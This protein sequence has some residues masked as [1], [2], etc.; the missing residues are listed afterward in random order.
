MEQI[1]MSETSTSTQAPNGQKP[2][3]RVLEQ[4]VLLSQVLDFVGEGTE[5]AAMLV[6]KDVCKFVRLLR[7]WQEEKK[8]E[9]KQEQRIVSWRSVSRVSAF[10]SSAVSLTEWGA[11]VLDMPMTETTTQ[12][13]VKGGHIS[14]LAWLLSKDVPL[15]RSQEGACLWAAKAGQLPMLQYLRS[16]KPPYPWN[17]L[18]YAYAAE[19]GHLDVLQ[20]AR[21]QPEPCPW[22]WRT[23]AHAAA[24]GHLEMLQWARSQPEPC[25][26]LEDM[27]ECCL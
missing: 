7:G 2:L 25:L 4:P 13:A 19:N 10:L 22:N 20:W 9:G 23:C 16:M 11:N 12:L 5:I 6:S 17:E 15:D 24:N 1:R 8:E 21:S 26:E 18:T 3:L 27:Y 14:A